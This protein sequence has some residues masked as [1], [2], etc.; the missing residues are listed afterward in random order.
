[1]FASDATITTTVKIAPLAKSITV[2]NLLALMVINLSVGAHF[3]DLYMFLIL[4]ILTF[5]KNFI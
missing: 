4:H 3:Q 5:N 2:V 1:M